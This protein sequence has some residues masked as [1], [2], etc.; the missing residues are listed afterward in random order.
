MVNLEKKNW[1][2]YSALQREYKSFEG[3]I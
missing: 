3:G 1:E 2:L